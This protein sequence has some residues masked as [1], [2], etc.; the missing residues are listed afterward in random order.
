[1]T[2]LHTKTDAHYLLQSID[3]EALCL[4]DTRLALMEIMNMRLPMEDVYGAAGELEARIRRIL[5]QLERKYI[6]SE[7]SYS[8]MA[9]TARVMADMIGKTCALPAK[10]HSVILCVFL[11]NHLNQLL[12][13]FEVA[14]G[15][16][17]K[18]TGSLVQP[19]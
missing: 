10:E 5:R 14:V 1:M 18:H 7:E 11:R 3:D 13:F 6:R 19:R 16:R 12:Y 17:E 15:L 2:A 4:S 8:Y 9:N